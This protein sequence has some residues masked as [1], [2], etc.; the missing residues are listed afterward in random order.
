MLTDDK[1]ILGT[2]LSIAYPILDGILFVPAILV[3][4]SL[5]RGDLAYAHWILMSLFIIFNGI[6]DIGFGYGAVLGTVINQEWIWDFSFTLAI[7]L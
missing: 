5:R 7:L 6:G 2:A 4:W 3:L 1:N